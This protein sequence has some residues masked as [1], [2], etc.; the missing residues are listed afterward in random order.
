MTLPGGS[1][2]ELPRI[3]A[4][5][6]TVDSLKQKNNPPRLLTWF[7]D[8]TWSQHT[9]FTFYCGGR[10]SVPGVRGAGMSWPCAICLFPP[11]HVH[12]HAR[13]GAHSHQLILQIL[14]AAGQTAD[15]LFSIKTQYLSYKRLRFPGSVLL[16]WGATAY[17]ELGAMLV[18]DSACGLDRNKKRMGGHLAWRLTYSE[19]STHAGVFHFVKVHT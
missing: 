12:S 3:L 6:Q 8:S 11:T 18:V 16:T 5:R 2:P 17:K 1:S 13:W 19:R 10:P 14:T 15:I 7:P 4:P 9:V